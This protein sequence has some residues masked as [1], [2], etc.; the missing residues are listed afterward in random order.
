MWNFLWYSIIIPVVVFILHGIGV[1]SV[2]TNTFQ[3]LHHISKV[4]LHQTLGTDRQFLSPWPWLG[5]HVVHGVAGQRTC[6]CLT[7]PGICAFEPA[8]SD[9]S[10]LP[11]TKRS[12]KSH[13]CVNLSHKPVAVPLFHFWLSR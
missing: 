4:L 13:W 8:D 10:I 1:L 6:V 5:F 7:T 12:R 2:C 3:I 9:S 11:G